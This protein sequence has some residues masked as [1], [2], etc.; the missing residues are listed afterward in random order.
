M[1]RA[2]LLCDAAG[3]IEPRHL[4]LDE[5]ARVAGNGAALAGAATPTG[6]G[7]VSAPAYAASFGA[8]SGGLADELWEEET[9]RIVTALASSRGREQA[10]ELLGISGRTLR[11]KLQKM[12]KAGI[13]VP[14][15]RA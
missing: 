7:A 15:D 12:R 3:V 11:Y 5:R 6:T 4:V 8:P 1:Q 10:A 13:Q 2:L 9:R 14:G